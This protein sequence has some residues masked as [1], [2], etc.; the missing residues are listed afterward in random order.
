[1]ELHTKDA[2]FRNRRSK[3]HPVLTPPNGSLPLPRVQV[4]AMHKIKR[5][6]LRDTRKQRIPHPIAHRIPPNLRHLHPLARFGIH[7]GQP[8]HIA[9]KDPNPE[10]IAL[11]VPA[12]QHLRANANPQQHPAPAHKL[13]QLTHN[14]L[15]VQIVHRRPRVPNPRE[16]NSIR[17]AHNLRRRPNSSPNPQG[18]Q[19]SSHAPQISRPIVQ[20]N[21]THTLVYRIF[22]Y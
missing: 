19:G 5:T 16:H 15:G 21:S 1:M 2:A 9:F 20:Q 13:P 22:S 14:T 11:F 3:A 10:T 7:T 12:K 18:L 6:I 4:I 17:A 8:P